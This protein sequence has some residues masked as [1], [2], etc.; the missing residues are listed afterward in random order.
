MSLSEILRKLCSIKDKVV[1]EAERDLD[2]F[3]VVQNEK[4]RNGVSRRL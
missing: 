2:R 3:V 1:D 4:L